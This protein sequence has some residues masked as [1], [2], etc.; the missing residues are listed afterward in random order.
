MLACGVTGLHPVSGSRS[1]GSLF[2]GPAVLVRQP[3]VTYC[4]RIGPGPEIASP[5]SGVQRPGGV[6]PD[7]LARV[8]GLRVQRPSD[9]RGAAVSGRSVL[10]RALD[11][12]MRDRL[13]LVNV[14]RLAEV[15]EGTVHQS[16]R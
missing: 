8:I 4:F 13:V 3:R 5:D 6:Q 12:A 7:R 10:A 2:G 11:R 16:G 14:A 1:G 15:P 9:S